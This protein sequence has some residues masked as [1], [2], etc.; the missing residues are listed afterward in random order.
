M[1]TFSA[2]CDFPYIE[3]DK[4][5]RSIMELDEARDQLLAQ[6]VLFEIPQPEM[7]ILQVTKK[8]LSLNKQLWDFVFMVKSWV[9]LWESTLWKDIDSEL[10]DMELKRFGKDLKG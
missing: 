1:Y 4:A 3:I 9:D 2:E 5:N 10:I 8:S 7:N 6:A